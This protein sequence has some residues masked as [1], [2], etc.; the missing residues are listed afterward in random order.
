MTEFDPKAIEA[1][2]REMI[3]AGADP[4]DMIDGLIWSAM[5]L[6]ISVDRLDLFYSS[7][8]RLWEEGRELVA[9]KVGDGPKPW[10]F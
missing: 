3:D 10:E 1:K 2:V 9:R 8:A 5:V 4:D 6:A 7:G